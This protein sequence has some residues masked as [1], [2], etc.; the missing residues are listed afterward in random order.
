[1]INFDNVTKED[2]KEHNQNQPKIS[3]HLHKIL[4]IRCSGSGKVN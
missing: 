4:I 2:I 3:G 1:M